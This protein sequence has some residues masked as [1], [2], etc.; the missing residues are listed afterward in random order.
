MKHTKKLL[1]LLLALALGLGLAL[2]AMAEEVRYNL[3]TPWEDVIITYP[4]GDSDSRYQVAHGASFTLIIEAA[5]PND[6]EISYQWRCYTREEDWVLIEGATGP[7]F[8][9][10]PGSKYYPSP[11][12]TLFDDMPFSTQTGFY[13]CQI[14]LVRTDAGGAVVD[15]Y[16]ACI[17][18]IIVEVEAER[19]ATAWERFRYIGLVGGLGLATAFGI[20]TGGLGYLIFPVIY[21]IC[22]VI[23]MFT[24]LP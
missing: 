15:T 21:P 4:R 7:S 20:F 3:Y 8:A 23:A 11:G 12:N 2:P 14:T 10:V 1:A 13:D 5:L 16:D 19:K 17:N 18:T 6:V 24:M 9:S 22:V